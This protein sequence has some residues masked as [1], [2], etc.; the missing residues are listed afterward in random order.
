MVKP[1]VRFDGEKEPVNVLFPGTTVIRGKTRVAPKALDDTGLLVYASWDDKTKGANF[2]RA[3]GGTGCGQ[4]GAPCI[5]TNE[6]VKG[7]ALSARTGALADSYRNIDYQRGTILC[8]VRKDPQIR[9]E[10]TYVPDPAVTCKAGASQWNNYGECL[11]G[12]NGFPQIAAGSQSG[13]TL[14]R[15]RSWK[16]KT[17]YLQATYQGMGRQIRYVQAPF[18]WTEKWRHVAVLW[19]IKARRLELYIDG[20]RA[21]KADPGK[22]EWYGAPWDRGRPSGQIFSPISCDHGKWS[23]TQRDEFYIY[24]RPLSPAEIMANKRKAA[25]K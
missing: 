19:D 15:Y 9:N 25:A 12:M 21:G 2:D 11:F 3:A 16:G 10:N 8:W 22:E 1:V 20:Q 5:Y 24:N 6:G 13:I 4:S 14:R 17:G 23:G 7:W 18:A